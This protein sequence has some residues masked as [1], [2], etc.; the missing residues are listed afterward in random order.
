MPDTLVYIDATGISHLAPL[1]Y[2]PP[3][4]RT[5]RLLLFV[6]VLAAYVAALV[7]AA[8]RSGKD[9]SLW[10]YLAFG[11][12]RY[13]VFQYLPTI[14]G[15]SLL[16]WLFEIQIA[17]YRIAPF[18]ALA[19]DQH[20][21]RSR[22]TLLPIYPSGFL[23]PTLSHAAAG[24]LAIS[25]F[26]FVAWLALVTVPLLSSAFNVYSRDDQWYWLA[27]QGIIWT[28]ITLYCLLIFATILLM[29]YLRR[30]QTGLR[31]DPRSLAD[32]L[33]LVANSNLLSEYAGYTEDTSSV[34]FRGEIEA[35]GDRLGYWCLAHSN[36][37]D[38][39][40]IFHA[41]GAPILSQTPAS[42][43]FSDSPI[44]EKPRH[45][46]LTGSARHSRF[47]HNPRAFNGHSK[48]SYASSIPGDDLGVDEYLP[49][50]LRPLSNLIWAFLAFGLFIAFVV[51]SYLPSTAISK[52]FSPSISV[53]VDSAGFGAASFLWSFI[54]SLLG[55]LCFLFWYSIDL[56]LR[57][58]QLYASLSLPDGEEA[59]KSILQE[60]IASGLGLVTLRAF[61]YR[62]IRIGL[63]SLTTL[64]AATLPILAGGIFW[65][66]FFIST[67]RIRI[68]GQMPAFYVLTG[69][70][71]IYAASYIFL[72]PKTA[73][74]AQRYSIP[75]PVKFHA[76][77]TNRGRSLIELIALTH[78]SKLLHDPAIRHA[79][80]HVTMS[81]K[82]RAPY[83][84]LR[85]PSPSGNPI[86]SSPI[87]EG[88]T[89]VNPPA[90]AGLDDVKGRSAELFEPVKYG[91]GTFIGSGGVDRWGIDRVKRNGVVVMSVRCP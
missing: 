76:G 63:A 91:V 15:M 82:L 36:Q 53:P 61:R 85:R 72:L 28:A 29:L 12:A 52:G 89:P 1:T 83:A 57:R 90:T 81:A 8:I 66:Q 40:N 33:T 62:H 31:W 45:G 22:G 3:I 34:D 71:A 49:W 25:F 19:S 5:S 51:L 16:L 38:P 46:V 73:R 60:Y 55:L 50:F 56:N 35:R 27:T 4:L 42:P 88:E 21:P 58:L 54:P 11:D 47:S 23:L 2:K 24:Q 26:L 80:S 30:R 68:S 9:S 87:G 70:V 44:K 37:N 78:H 10:R 64:L 7:Y 67:Q 41:F 6:L 43:I 69:V 14:I 65:A 18:I 17:L 77:M 20:R 59:I 84:D 86:I 32:V 79:Q 39:A 74:G 75:N 13:F 48:M